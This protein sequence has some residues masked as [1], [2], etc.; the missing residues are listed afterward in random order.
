MK[1]HVKTVISGTKFHYG[2]A[3]TS[4]NPF[5]LGDEVTVERNFI[6]QDLIQASQKPHFF[7]NPTKNTGGELCLPFFFPKNYMSISA[8]DWNDGRNN[9]FFI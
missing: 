9:Y 5:T 2:R 6:Q 7:L 3:L 8:G 4:Y 1:L